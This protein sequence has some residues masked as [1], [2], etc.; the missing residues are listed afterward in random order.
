MDEVK[1]YENTPLDTIKS[2]IKDN[3]NN[4]SRAFI[5]IGYYLKDLRDRELFSAD[6]YENIWEFAH[7]EF[8]IS[9]S[10]AS[11]L[12]SINDR[13][14]IDG[15]SP[16][17]LEQYKDFSSSK[18]QEMLYLT[19]DQLEQVSLTTTVAQIRDIRNPEKSV[20]TSKQE[21]VVSEKVIQ[22]SRYQV[23]KEICDSICKM[24]SYI[25]EKNRYSMET[26]QGLSTVDHSF[27]FG[28]DGDGHSKYDAVCKNSQY[29]VEEFN[30]EGK[31]IFESG[32]VNQYIWNFNGREW[33]KDHPE[34]EKPSG[35][36]IHRFEFICTLPEASKLATMNGEN[37]S[38][39][40]CWN[41]SKHNTCGYECNSSAHRPNIVD[42][43]ETVIK[44]SDTIIDQDTTLPCDTCGWDVQGCCN[45]DS[46]EDDYCVKGDKWTSS[47]ETVEAEV[48]HTEKDP[49]EYSLSD[50][51]W[52]I[53][54]H[55]NSLEVLRQDSTVSPARY[56]TK[57]R[58]DAATTLLDKLK[59]PV[60][61]IKPDQEVVQ[62]ELI[63][64]KN[65][66]QRKD[67]IDN[68]TSWPVWID[69]ELTGERYYR[70]DLLD[71]AAIVVKV[72]RKHAWKSYK[73]IKDY[74]YGAEQY[75]LLG[76]KSDWSQKGTK[77]TVDDSRTF[78]ECNTNKSALVE[79]LKEFQKKG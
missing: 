47:V 74:E 56:K 36:C 13:F 20:S 43:E 40:C 51:E 2:I 46:S 16:E 66:D 26:I 14:S 37:C 72:S 60:I 64:L 58:L 52:E 65:N 19:D 22:Q 76:V 75:Y 21:T 45:Y 49:E 8:G 12:M 29:H 25:L 1:W 61:D 34:E 78:Y 7:S 33:L 59:E 57:M 67:F 55:T 38:A 10:Q 6:G 42:E 35:K 44:T 70:Y 30:G 62:P 79:Y 50:V 17:L 73:E 32:E 24:S 3:I 27:G 4:A 63:I 9:K 68:Y 15:N 69:Q 71:K 77:F 48:I 53:R 54:T 28:N 18:L 5:K 41:C 11:K 39:S 23:L 31:W